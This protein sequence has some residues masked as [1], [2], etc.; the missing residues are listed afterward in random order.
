MSYKCATPTCGA[1][2][3]DWTVLR[4][5]ASSYN[6][7]NKKRVCSKCRDELVEVFGW[8]VLWDNGNVPTTP[9]PH[10]DD[11]VDAAALRWRALLEQRLSELDS[12]DPLYHRGLSEGTL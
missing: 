12:D 5:D 1:K 11:E 7:H 2:S 4:P 10:D 9:A 3:A 6:P 8:H